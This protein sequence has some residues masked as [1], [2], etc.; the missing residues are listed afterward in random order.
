MK[1]A[2]R[3]LSI[4]LALMMALGVFSLAAVAADPADYTA[5]NAA[6]STNLPGAADRK[7]YTPEAN[8]LIDNVVNNL[9]DWDLT[10]D[11]QATV[12]GYVTMVTDLGLFLKSFVTA[13]GQTLSFD[14]GSGYAAYVP[15]YPYGAAGVNFYPFRAEQNCVFD[16]GFEASVAALPVGST[17]TFTVTIK[18]NTVDLMLAGGIPF[19]FDQTKLEVVGNNGNN[20]SFP[21]TE[22]GTNIAVKYK[23]TATLN[24]SVSTFWPVIYRN[25]AAFKAQ[26][27]AVNIVVT[28][29]TTSG[30]PRCVTTGGVDE[31]ILQFTFRLKAGAT[32]GDAVIYIDPAFK[33]DVLNRQNALYL[34][35][36]K[37]ADAMVVYD[38]LAS[39]GTTID[40]ADARAV[41][42]IVGETTITVDPANGEATY[43]VTGFPDAAVPA[44]TEPVWEGHTFT[45]WN[46]PIPATFPM[47]SFTAVA[48]WD[49][50][51]YNAVFKVD[52]VEY[53][54]V[55]TPFGA[56]IVPPAD[57]TKEGYTFS[58]WD[59]IPPSM[60]AQNVEI[61]GTLDINTYNA[62]FESDGAV[63]Q[64]V[65]TQF[66]AEIQVPAPP[67]KEGYVFE[68]WLPEP[69]TMGAG[70][71]VFVAQ[72]RQN[73][74]IISVTNENVY[75]IGQYTE[76]TVL[77]KGSPIK[78]Q[79]AR[80]TN[81]AS[82]QTY[83]RGNN[84]NILSITPTMYDY[85]D[86]PMPCEI[87]V[88]KMFIST[89][90]CEMLARAKY[91][92]DPNG[93]YGL[94]YHSFFISP[95]PSD[96]AV[97]DVQIDADKFVY[98]FTSTITIKTGPDAT[99]V[100]LTNLAGSTRTYG[101]AYTPYVDQNGFR[102]WTITT[103]F[104]ALGPHSWTVTA[105]DIKGTANL[106]AA[107][108]T[109][110]VYQF[111]VPIDPGRGV[112][113]VALAE[114]RVLWNTP[115][116]V[117]VTTEIDSTA[118]LVTS[119]GG[120]VQKFTAANATFFDEAGTRI[121][122]VPVKF[123]ALGECTYTVSAMFG[124]VTAA[125]TKDFTVTVLY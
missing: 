61:N 52:G 104:G 12:N 17:N 57:P 32:A 99:K 95:A 115:T 113:S 111:E 55:P 84:A 56:A 15:V 31:S 112:I 66:G 18:L 13:E 106:A 29:D 48:Q 63:Y 110:T 81:L 79:F 116:D 36:A 20:A 65:P 114:N 38:T 101:I 121:W 45:A 108:L 125:A 119:S 37:N 33:R 30:L 117:T 124:T 67:D 26:W 123:G 5:V 100:R 28:Q 9:I 58:G 88:I 74:D 53:T 43:P 44:V 7:Y 4:V 90:E 21:V 70:N 46:P 25:D 91:G 109:F 120:I 102:Y 97:Y 24:P 22:L 82:T 50:N 85:G 86:G 2:K 35:R 92:E 75:K 10:T 14:Y 73:V 80:A 40:V 83:W 118:V 3:T 89:S 71:E 69:G 34:S 19:L 54:T 77:V 76:F 72:W 42:K 59:V 39:Y 49:L 41:V 60:P 16:L 6:I 93:P 1:M 68:G 11:D 23:Y 94:Y 8:A 27:G 103:K 78:I 107:S 98:G 64:T 96:A 51:T 122:S 47:E 62:I 87:W 105:Y